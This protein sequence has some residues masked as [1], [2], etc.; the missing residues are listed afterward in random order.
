[1]DDATYRK[2]LVRLRAHIKIIENNLRER[3]YTFDY[4]KQPSKAMFKYRKAFI[5]NDGERYNSFLNKVATGEAKINANTLAP[6]ELV[7]PYLNR[8]LHL[9][10]FASSKK[11]R[12][13]RSQT[14]KSSKYFHSIGFALFH[15][16][17]T[18]R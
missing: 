12:Y 9:R 17:H 14:E 5:R 3:D 18:G 8:F 4:E 10:L 7:E 13:S 6:Y 11:S 1:M 15:I 16:N 2:I